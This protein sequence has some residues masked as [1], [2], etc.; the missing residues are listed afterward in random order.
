MVNI[1]CVQHCPV[2][3]LPKMKPLVWRMVK[4]YEECE[5]QKA[6]AQLMVDCPQFYSEYFASNWMT[7]K[8][9]WASHLTQHVFTGGVIASSYA[10]SSGAAQGKWLQSPRHSLVDILL[11]CLEKEDLDIKKSRKNLAVI[12]HF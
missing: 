1:N 11:S 4:E 12:F 3:E 10:E 5:F 8:H 7:R 2:H 9:R 6:H